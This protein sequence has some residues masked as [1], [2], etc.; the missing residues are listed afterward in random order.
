VKQSAPQGSTV[1]ICVTGGAGY[2]GSILVPKL[3]S[4]GHEV[5]VVDS[6][7]YNQTSLLDVMNSPK[8][9]L[10]RADVREFSSYNDVLKESDVVIPLA[11]LTG[12]P[13]CD[14]KPREAKEVNLQ[15]IA[16]TKKRLS[17]SQRILFPNTNSGYGVGEKDIFCN[18]ESALRPVSLYGRLKVEAEQ[19]LLER[20]NTVTF[21]LAT[22]FGPSPRMRLDLLVNDFAYRAYFD[23][24]VVL[25]EGH[26][27]RNYLHIQDAADA[28]L[29]ALDHFDA[30]KGRCY[31]VGLEDANLS[32]IELCELI[33]GHLPQFQYVESA[34]GSDPD[35][36]NY[37]VSN[38]RIKEAGFVAKTS[39]HEGIEQLIKTFQVIRDNRYRNA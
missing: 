26:F 18:E 14:Q 16:E 2:L 33:K 23:H 10:I 11:C 7:L 19:V 36:R 13:L 21:R 35:K 27:K 5:V 32:K 22:L 15:V 25:F 4:H 1:K 17:A 8:L 30:M 37:I 38:E 20:E 3:I 28:F 6:F 12:A 39:L 29:H 9:T 34:I 24:T 31:N